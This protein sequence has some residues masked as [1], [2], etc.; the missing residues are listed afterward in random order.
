MFEQNYIGVKNVN[1]FSQWLP[2]SKFAW[3]MTIL[4]IIGFIIGSIGTYATLAQIYHFPV[5]FHQ[6]EEQ[7]QPDPRSSICDL[8]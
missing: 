4:G 2:K 5:P 3:I 1:N 6:W 8:Q 7:K